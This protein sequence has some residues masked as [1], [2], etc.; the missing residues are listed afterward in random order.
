MQTSCVGASVGCCVGCVGDAV[1]ALHD[2][3]AVR[4]VEAAAFTPLIPA[5][6]DVP[7]AVATPFVVVVVVEVEAEEEAFSPSP[8]KESPSRSAEALALDTADDRLIPSSVVAPGETARERRAHATKR[9]HTMS[10]RR[11]MPRGMMRTTPDVRHEKLS[12]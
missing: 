8:P 2:R 3:R 10:A 4:A 7:L 6:D 12:K 9:P 1:A 5:P 11:W